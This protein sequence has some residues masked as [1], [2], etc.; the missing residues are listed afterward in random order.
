MRNKKSFIIA[1]ILLVAVAIFARYQN[2][3]VAAQA[4]Q[5]H[6]DQGTQ[7]FKINKASKL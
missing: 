4:Y 1:V 2:N 7:A 3:Q 5:N 6:V